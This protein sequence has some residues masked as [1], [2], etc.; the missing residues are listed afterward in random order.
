MGGGEIITPYYVAITLI[1]NTLS[2]SGNTLYCYASTQVKSGYKAGTTVILQRKNGSD[3]DDVTSWSTSANTSAT[4]DKTYTAT[5][6]NTY[7]LMVSHY[8]Y[9][10]NGALLEADVSYSSTVSY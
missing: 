1:D 10:S 2:R 9:N 6:G 7:R 8:S 4:I 3:W 5:T